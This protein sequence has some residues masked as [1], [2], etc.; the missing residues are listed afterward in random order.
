MQDSIRLSQKGVGGLLGSMSADVKKELGPLF[1]LMNNMVH[2]ND[3][4]LSLLY[5]HSFSYQRRLLKGII[6]RYCL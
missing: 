5:L 4:R 3:K 2:G 1:N 6:A